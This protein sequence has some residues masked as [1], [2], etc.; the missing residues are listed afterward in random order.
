[1]KPLL[2]L[3]LLFAGTFSPFAAEGQK[4]VLLYSRYFNAIGETRYQPDG[5]YKEVLTRLRGEF[6]IRIHAEE[7]QRTK[8]RI[9]SLYAK[10]CG[11]SYEDV[12][13]ALDRDRFMTAEEALDWGL[14]DRVLDRRDAMSE[15]PVPV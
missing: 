12:E 3:V 13:R 11:R 10:H 15:G 5:N 1:M 2:L 9:T 8:H 6:D 14:I 4:P 7:M